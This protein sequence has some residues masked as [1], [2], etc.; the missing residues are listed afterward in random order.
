MRLE[1]LCGLGKIMMGIKAWESLDDD[2]QCGRTKK[3][4]YQLTKICE[5]LFESF[6]S[7]ALGF[8]MVL[9]NDR[10]SLVNT[11]ILSIVFS[12]INVTNVFISIY[13]SNRLK[14]KNND[15]NDKHEE[16]KSCNFDLDTLVLNQQE[17]DDN[18]DGA[19]VDDLDFKSP[20]DNE[21]ESKNE[22]VWTVVEKK[23]FCCKNPCKIPVCRYESTIKDEC[24]DNGASTLNQ[25]LSLDFFDYSRKELLSLFF[26]YLWVLL[27]FYIRIYPSLMI[28]ILLNNVKQ[29]Q[30][31]LF[32]FVSIP[33]IEILGFWCFVLN[34]QKPKTFGI[35]NI[36]N[37]IL[38]LFSCVFTMSYFV[39]EKV[40]GIQ[41]KHSKNKYGSVKTTDTE[42]D[43]ENE[44]RRK[45]VL[46]ILKY[47]F[48]SIL[49]S[50]CLFLF[51][52]LLDFLATK[53]WSFSLVFYIV[54]LVLFLF[55]L[56]LT[57]HYYFTKKNQSIQ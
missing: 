45:A 28:F 12:V 1:L 57:S 9:V 49:F 41:F 46:G 10:N 44:R 39:F 55:H 38:I 7:I 26:V 6:P 34:F 17:I 54:C 36:E 3:S 40:F 31:S 21:D 13:N 15:N 8:Y 20:Y 30:F 18:N 23:S 37:A 29:A 5:V 14:K 4:N 48:F 22:D 51:C 16:G 27:D 32:M 53:D 19:I 50:F 56:V 43:K 2:T 35:S 24:S 25:I 47:E 33:C 42:N 11:A 52:F